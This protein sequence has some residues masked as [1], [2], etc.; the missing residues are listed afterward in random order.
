MNLLIL[1]MVL[2]VVL[3]VVLL[4]LLNIKEECIPTNS[5]IFRDDNI[6]NNIETL[7]EKIDE[8]YV[9]KT[10]IYYSITQTFGKKYFCHWSILAKTNKGNMFIISPTGHGSVNVHE[11]L[12]EYIYEANGYKF[13]RGGTLGKHIIFPKKIIPKFSINVNDVIYEMM[14]TNE[15]IKYLP[16][17]MN[18][19]FVVS[20]VLGLYQNGRIPK[21]STIDSMKRVINDLMFGYK[22]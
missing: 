18:C 9:A 1:C 12:K 6:Y 21:I 11:V 10:G 2:C 8:M 19:Q 3:C 4:C 14:K 5:V 7:N 17:S 15:N 22:F 13:I 20:Y 16:F